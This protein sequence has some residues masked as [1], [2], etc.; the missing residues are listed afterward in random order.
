VTANEI[1]TE[2]ESLLAKSSWWK[3]FVGS[4]F[5]SYL[6]LFIAQL[7][8]RVTRTSERNLQESFLSL[9]TKRTSVLAGAEDRGYVGRK[10]SPSKGV[11]AITNK[12]AARYDVPQYATLTG[13]NQLPYMVMEGVSI[14]AGETIH[15]ATEQIERAYSVLTAANDE[16]WLSVALPIETTQNTHKL[17][18]R[19][20][21]EEWEERF[22]FRNATPTSQ[23]YAENYKSTDQLSIRF[24]NDITGK[25]IEQG[26]VIELEY[27]L[28]EGATTLIDGQKLEFTGGFENL[29]EGLTVQTHTAVIGGDE[30]E[31]LESI[32]D[33]ALY[34]SVYDEQVVWDG[35]FKSFIQ[36]N[37]AGLSFLQVWGESEQEQLDGASS[38][39]NI[40][41]VF[42]CAY[43]G[44]KGEAVNA[45]ILELFEGRE[46]YNEKYVTAPRVDTPFTVT[47]IGKVYAN[48]DPSKAETIVQEALTSMYGKN[49]TSVRPSITKNALWKHVEALV[50]EYGI[51]SF[52]L[53]VTGLEENPSINVYQYLDEVGSSATF[54]YI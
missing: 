35:D 17:I 12:G 22:K 52:E 49:V 36:R 40:N 6:S 44:T 37:V 3:R 4:Q 38:V 29:N 24:G 26:D 14:E 45:E 47:V 18:V 28:T 32:R 5:V 54:S 39:L 41:K 51:E 42:I 10:I 43:S 31:D 46:A 20:N 30:A 23:V 25:A 33:G 48:A 53:E 21:D 1:K 11:L 50:D 8:E 27:W 7:L 9:A 34:S 15:V 19:V 16:K 2:L 13:S